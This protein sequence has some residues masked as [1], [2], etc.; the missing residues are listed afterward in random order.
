MSAAG[1]LTLRQRAQDPDLVDRALTMVDD[2]RRENAELRAQVRILH[3]LGPLVEALIRRL[4]DAE[5]ERDA[6]TQVTI[7]N[8]LRPIVIDS[9]DRPKRRHGLK[10]C[11]DCGELYEYRG[12]RSTRCVPCMKIHRQKWRAE[13]LARLKPQPQEIP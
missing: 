13:R 4:D 3:T 12:G 8:E 7:S 2:L 6:A 10:P 1:P 11:A 9:P 5:R